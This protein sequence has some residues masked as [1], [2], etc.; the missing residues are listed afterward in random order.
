MNVST[1]TAHGYSR[2][3]RRAVAELLDAGHDDSS[4]AL[5]PLA[6]DVLVADQFADLDRL[7]ARDEAAVRLLG[8]E[9]EILAADARHGRD[10][11]R[12]AGRR[13]PDDPGA[14]ELLH[15]ERRRRLPQRALHQHGLRRFVH[16]RRDERDR[17]GGRDLPRR[18]SSICTGRPS[19][20][21]GER[22]S[23]TWMS[24]SSAELSSIVVITVEVRHAIADANRDV[25]DDAGLR[26]RRRGSTAARPA[27]RAPGRRAPPGAPPPCAA[28]SAPARIP[29]G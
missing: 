15:A 11:H 27:L 19:R 25:A 10:R 24:A 7:L 23:G 4:P 20:R 28:S 12:Q 5:R 29:A 16:A 3:D 14:R 26:R 18:L 1:M 9:A 2:F 22:S 17:V 13:A 8:H 6:D 21:S